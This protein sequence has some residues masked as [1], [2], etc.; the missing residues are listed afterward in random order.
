MNKIFKLLQ[1]KM[2]NHYEIIFLKS[3]CINISSKHIKF[4][5]IKIFLF[6]QIIDP[7]ESYTN[8]Y[9]K[10][11]NEKRKIILEK[12]LLKL[13]IMMNLYDSW[14]IIIYNQKKMCHQKI[15]E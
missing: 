12:L 8:N 5:Q 14:K 6:K 11:A 2:S 10:V 13:N 7:F 3:V 9:N 15:M 1:L 4:K